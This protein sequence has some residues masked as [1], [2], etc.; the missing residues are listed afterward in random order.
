RPRSST[1]SAAS[2]PTRSPTRSWTAAPGSSRSA[3]TSPTSRRR[4][5]RPGR[6]SARSPRRPRTPASGPAELVELGVVD[7]VV[8]RDLVHE[9]DVHLVAQLLEVGAGREQRL[10][11]EHD[12]IGQLAEAVAVALGEGRALVEPEQVER[13]VGGPVL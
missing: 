4:P 13:A 2:A 12:A 3:P 7:A 11:V 6:P 9:R 8:V 1:S 10:A 5:R